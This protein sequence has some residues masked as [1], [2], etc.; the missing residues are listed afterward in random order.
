LKALR[1]KSPPRETVGLRPF[2]VTVS[3]TEVVTITVP[4][5]LP[6]G[7]TIPEGAFK[8]AIVGFVGM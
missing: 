4:I 1:L 8:V 2:T 6:H 5:V 3:N 7:A